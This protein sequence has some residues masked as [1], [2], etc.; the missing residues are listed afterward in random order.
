MRAEQLPRAGT[1]AR[2]RGEAPAWA[3]IRAGYEGNIVVAS[4][5]FIILGIASIFF[6]SAMLITVA[7]LLRGRWNQ[8]GGP[9]SNRRP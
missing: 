8:M 4:S 7:L 6:L 2:M 5:A 3:R 9:P 1:Y